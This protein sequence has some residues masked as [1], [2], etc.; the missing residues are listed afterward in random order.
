MESREKAL[1]DEA[2]EVVEAAI[3]RHE[4]FDKAIKAQVK[5]IYLRININIFLFLQE[6]KINNLK[7]FAGQLVSQDHYEKTGID[8]RLQRVLDRWTRLRQAMMEYRSRLGESQTLQDFSRDAEEI[9][10]WIA[11]KLAAASDEPVKETQN[12]QVRNPIILNSFASCTIVHNNNK[13][14]LNTWKYVYIG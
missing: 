13:N 12:L 1:K 9:E 14:I 2:V 3:K 4:D 5:F 8:D 7:Q 6:D 11:D 10:A